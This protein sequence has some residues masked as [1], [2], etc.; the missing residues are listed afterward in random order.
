MEEGLNS[1]RSELIEEGEPRKKHSQ[2]DFRLCLEERVGHLLRRAYQRH[3]MVFQTHLSE[4]DL[5]AAQYIALANLLERGVCS[6]SDLAR[7]TAI[8][9]TTIRGIISRLKKRGLL[10]TEVDSSDARKVTVTL[11]TQGQ[12]VAAKAY[13]RIDGISEET[14]NGIDDVE[15]SA[16]KYLLRRL[17]DLSTT[18]ERRPTD[19]SAPDL[20]DG[21]ESS[22]NRSQGDVG[23]SFQLQLDERVGYLLRRAYQRHVTVFQY[24]LNEFQLTAAQYI[25]LA[26]LLEHK[27][28]SQSD[29]VRHTIMDHTTIRG[30]I[31]RL[32]ARGFLSS[33]ADPS[34]ARKIMV[35][36]T[37]NGQAIANEASTRIDVVSEETCNGINDAERVALKYLLRR[38]ANIPLA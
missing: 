21:T 10:L 4:F 3:V 2:P 16:L 14:F 35:S 24:Y 5:T 31:S 20:A 26:T 9:H 15:R 22:D 1:V 28:C 30:I 7:F 38:I 36:L 34:D 29:L 6:Q 25:V 19:T 13:T 27:V 17:A 32:G 11:T 12:T 37:A 18:T 8:D 23:S 33:E